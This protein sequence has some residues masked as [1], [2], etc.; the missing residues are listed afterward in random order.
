MTAVSTRIA[1]AS[2]LPAFLAGMPV[3][4]NMAKI[5]TDAE[6]GQALVSLEYLQCIDNDEVSGR[7]AAGMSHCVHIEHPKG[8]T[9]EQ[10]LCVDY[11]A[12]IDR[13]TIAR[14]VYRGQKR[15]YSR[16]W[17]GTKGD[18]QPESLGSGGKYDAVETRGDG[19]LDL[20][21]KDGRW[22]PDFRR[23]PTNTII[24]D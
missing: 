15:V 21:Y 1:L 16:Y 7:M 23:T 24:E 22:S 6:V 12:D 20:I 4:A 9:F 19:A 17:I 2:S 10:L 8:V 18:K 14:C 13:N 5:P 3:N 11:G